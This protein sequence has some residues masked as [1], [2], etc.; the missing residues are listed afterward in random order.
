MIYLEA[1]IYETLRLVQQSITLRKVM[2]PCTL[3]TERGEIALNPPFY[4]ATLLSVTNMDE[5]HLDQHIPDLH[6]FRP[7]RLLNA[8]GTGPVA[9]RLSGKAA[10]GTETLTSTFGHFSHA[11]PGR[12]LAVAVSKIVLTRILQS[13]QLT[14][15]FTHATVPPTSVGALARV[16]EP[17]IVDYQ[18]RA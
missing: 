10:E 8:D 5:K 14:P 7:E 18:T 12:R 13:W 16:A 2:A 15:R 17:C 9:L 6:K 11:C 1:V 3:S 4:L